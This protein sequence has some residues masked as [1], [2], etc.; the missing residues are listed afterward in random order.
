MIRAG[1]PEA[2][3]PEEPWTVYY[4]EFSQF[5]DAHKGTFSETS[6]V[7]GFLDLSNYSDAQMA[8]KLWRFCHTSSKNREDA[9]R[10]VRNYPSTKKPKIE[11]PRPTPPGSPAY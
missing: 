3:S 4:A 6:F 2:F 10:F 5:L 9:L 11:P 7:V 8:D 1:S